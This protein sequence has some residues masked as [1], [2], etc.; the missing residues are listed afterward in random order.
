MIYHQR[1]LRSSA[2]PVAAVLI[3]LG[4]TNASALSMGKLRVQSAL[5]QS[6]IAEIDLTDVSEEDAASLKSELA[7]PSTFTGMGLEYNVALNGTQIVLQRR[8]NGSR[9]LKVTGTRTLNDPFVDILVELS[10]GSGKIVRTYTL[11]LDPPKSQEAAPLP[12]LPAPLSDNQAAPPKAAAPVAATATPANTTLPANSASKKSSTNSM[13]APA[14]A[15]SGQQRVKVHTGDNAGKIAGAW[16]TDGVTVEQMLVAMLDANPAA[17]VGGNVNRLMANTEIVVPDAAAVKKTSPTEALHLIQRQNQEFQ[18]LRRTL[19]SQAPTAPATSKPAET[20]GKVTPAVPATSSKTASGDT[21]KLSK[22]NAQDVAEKANMEQIAQ[23]RAKNEA[24]ERARELAKNIEELN[25]LAKVAAKPEPVSSPPAPNATASSPAN[26]GSAP[27]AAPA[28]STPASNPVAPSVV[29]ATPSPS[30][31]PSGGLFESFTRN[32]DVGAL[33]L[34]LLGLLGGLGWY[35][36]MQA[37]KNSADGLSAPSK[38]NSSASTSFA[39]AQRVDTSEAINSSLHNSIYQESQ[40]ELANEL[41]PVAE[42]EVYL[43]YGK[44]VP[45]EEILKEGLQQ[46]PNRVAIHIKLLAIYAKRGDT[47]SFESIAQD[48][49]TLTQGDGSDWAQVLEM[50]LALD[51]TN[52]LYSEGINKAP[53][54]EAPNPGFQ[55]PIFQLEPDDLVALSKDKANAGAADNHADLPAVEESANASMP[56]PSQTAAPQRD[57]SFEEEPISLHV[58]AAVP[59][60][61]FATTERLDATLALAEQ[62]LEIGEKEGARALIEEVMAGGNESLRKRATELLAK[63]R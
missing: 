34:A 10:W 43:A 60:S 1:F 25:Q 9:Y 4:A 35:R 57:D 39:G 53:E 7:A 33:L 12:V 54:P 14:A 32:P 45:A 48:V 41:D 58:A 51:P 18:N 50:G 15:T 36:R 61:A 47:K 63:A 27:L 44:D 11:L 19:A 28:A 40:L 17:F 38:W 31:A 52:P 24:S 26:A 3:S 46:T 37:K 62:F 30:Q 22:G 21:L 56:L 6:L 5:G 2:A 13:L 29:A 59:E 8:Q 49:K 55:N 23:Q 16:L 42:A 20:A